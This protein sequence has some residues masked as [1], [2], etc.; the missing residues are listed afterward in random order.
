MILVYIEHRD[1]KIRKSSYEVLSVANK[2]GL[3]EVHA[4]IIGNNL[5]EMVESI[6]T[7]ADV[8]YCFE[9][10]SLENYSTMAYKKVLWELSKKLNPEAILFSASSLGKDLA[11]RVTAALNSSF[12]SDCISVNVMDGKIMATRPIYAGKALLTIELKKKPAVLTL[13]PNIFPVESGISKSGKAEFENIEITEEDISCKVVRIEKGEEVAIDVSEAEIVV[14][15]GRGMKGPENFALLRELCSIL[16]NCA[17]GASRAAVDAGWIDHQHQVGQTGKVVSPNLYM[18]FGIS[19]SIQHL[20][21]M[22]GSKII[23]AVNKDPDAP[24][25]KVANYGLVADLFEVIPVLKEEL[26]KIL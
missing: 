21:G 6:K 5:K 15:G 22:S 4:V 2:L 24:I 25:F 3:G 8:I 11:P 14:S 26:K 19:G 9:N 20:A 12:A 23:V 17:V 10:P 16:P 18:A 13:R 7:W 1:G